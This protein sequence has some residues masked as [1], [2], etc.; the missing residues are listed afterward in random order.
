[1][2][3]FGGSKTDCNSTESIRVGT[4][5]RQVKVNESQGGRRVVFGVD[6]AV[7]VGRRSSAAWA[8]RLPT[9]AAATNL[10]ARLGLGTTRDKRVAPLLLVQL[11]FIP[12]SMEHD[13]LDSDDSF[14]GEQYDDYLA[15]SDLEE[16]LER[17]T[18]SDRDQSPLANVKAMLDQMAD[19]VNRG[20][21][22]CMTIYP[23]PSVTLGASAGSPT[24]TRPSSYTLSFP[25]GSTNEARRFSS[26]LRNMLLLH[27]ADR[28][29]NISAGLRHDL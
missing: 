24:E 22:P 6:C 17:A 3:I 29:S 7:V 27:A 4:A 15:S 11:C 1:M 9:R 5:P 12:R 16:Q 26:A 21:P 23:R 28:S 14:V 10:L 19:A 8:T 20:E 2:S 25:G 13:Y 18:P